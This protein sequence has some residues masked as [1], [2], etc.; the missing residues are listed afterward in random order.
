MAVWAT[1]SQ[2]QN[3]ASSVY[4][5]ALLS[6]VIAMIKSLKPAPPPPCLHSASSLQFLN[7]K[8]VNEVIGHRFFLFIV[9]L[10]LSS[11]PIILAF[12]QGTLN[13]TDDRRIHGF[14]RKYSL[15]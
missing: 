15:R 2:K 7:E 1:V 13:H 14:F 10:A 11:L 5:E 9:F 12:R 3:P 8:T 4:I 6:R